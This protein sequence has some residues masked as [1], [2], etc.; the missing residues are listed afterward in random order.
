MDAPANLFGRIFVIHFEM[1][2]FGKQSFRLMLVLTALSPVY[3]AA[4][5]AVVAPKAASPPV[6]DGRLDDE[7]WK[8]A[9][10]FTDFKTFKPDYGKEPSQRTEAYFLFDAENFYVAFRC[11]DTEPGKIKANI[12]KRDDMFADDYVAFCLDTFSDAQNAYLLLINPLGIQGDGLMN[13][14]GNADPSMDFVWYSK[15]QIDDQ[16]YSVECRI[17]LQSLRF[18]SKKSVIMGMS[19]VRQIVRLSESSSFPAIFPDKGSLISQLQPV[20]ITGLRYDR[21]VEILPALTH[22]NH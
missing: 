18:S 16:G 19:F 17:P 11:F 15:G 1:R 7:A 14:V 21:V 9:L 3:A 12:S 5:E 10:K 2:T 6:I 22:S 4:V 20:S 8:T 13:S